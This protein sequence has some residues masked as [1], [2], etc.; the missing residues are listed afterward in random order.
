[1]SASD[2][3]SPAELEGTSLLAWQGD[4]AERMVGGIRSLLQ[5]HLYDAPYHRLQ[6]WRPDLSS[7]P[8]YA[9]WLSPLRQELA[10]QLGLPHDSRLPGELQLVSPASTIDGDGC[11]A[12]ASGYR[13]FAVRWSV[14]DGVY[15]EGLLLQPEVAPRARVLALPDCDNTPEQLA[16]LEPGLPK[17][18]QFARTL[19]HSGCRVLI[20]TLVDRDCRWSKIPGHL[21]TNMPHREFVYRAAYELGRHVLG[22]ELHRILAAID[23]L[24]A[25][26]RTST[27]SGPEPGPHGT[28]LALPL[29]IIGYGEGGLLATLAGALDE[30]LRTVAVSGSFG[31]REGVWE[32]PIYRNVFGQLKSFGDAE[33][34]AMVVPRTLIVEAAHHPAVDGP[35]PRTERRSGAAPGVI[36]TPS[37][38]QVKAEIDRAARLVASLAGSASC[39][40]LVTPE[41][42]RPG[43]GS[44]LRHFLLSL[45]AARDLAPVTAPARMQTPLLAAASA[46]TRRQRTV[47]QLIAHTQNALADAEFA[48]RR[49]WAK[50]VF[51]DADSFIGSCSYYR[52]YFER[53]VIGSLPSPHH[54]LRPLSR[55]IC[56]STHYRSYEVVIN[57][58]G[59]E[60]DSDHVFAS[61][62]LL[63]PKN[64][65]DSERRPAVVCQHGLEGRPRDLADPTVDNPSYNQYGCRLAER[66]YVVFAPQNPYIGG[67]SYRVIQRMA[68]PLGL[69]LFSVIVRQHQRILEWLGKLS[70]VDAE[71]IAFYGLSYGGKTAM[72]VPAMLDGYCLSIC[73]ADYNEWIWKNASTRHSYSYMATGEYD[74]PEFNLGN[75]FNYAEMSWLIFPRPFMVERGHHDGVAPDEWVAYEYARTQRHYVLLGHGDR[76]EIEFFDG[77]HT[78]HGKG[79]F[80]FLQRHLGFP[81]HD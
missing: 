47:Q 53:Q 43:S 54:T 4:L 66:G 41:D 63:V 7:A 52:R 79:T 81:A 74:M 44:F 27:G 49:F 68:N 34:A 10:G 57:V 80:E 65:T 55:L 76:T 1:M 77:P 24:E 35:P 62:I 20:P 29:G 51:D 61:G 12:R 37:T 6:R 48:R 26:D 36:A 23:A 69:S 22:Y 72:R 25:M 5:R 39:L 28:G 8:A 15:G 11:L 31:P 16:G 71:R 38:E 50:A 70:F 14:L 40:Q 60:G 32:Q 59:R 21:Q 64:L 19:V 30:R 9:H 45:G 78:I 33:L 73:S 67:D 56:E 46:A 3:P 58:Y 75:T 18:E 17:A 13:I 2:P 42:S